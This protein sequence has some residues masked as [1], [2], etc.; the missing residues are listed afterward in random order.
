MTPIR[1]A[2]HALEAL[3]DR[4][5]PI[6]PTPALRPDRRFAG[7]DA[8]VISRARRAR[9]GALFEMLWSGNWRGRYGSQSE[10]D[11]ALCGLLA[12]WCNGD[13][14]RVD[15][16]FRQSGLYRAKWDRADY[17]RWTLAR[18]CQPGGRA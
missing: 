17:R 2:Q 5:W 16:L 6:G 4:M 10:A 12:F 3:C 8:A 13:P 15:A 11:L 18:A 1:D 14:T 9:N 7:P